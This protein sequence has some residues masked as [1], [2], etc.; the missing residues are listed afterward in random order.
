MNYANIINVDKIINQ[1]K[2]MI[3]M[4]ETWEEAI[5]RLVSYMAERTLTEDDYDEVE[6]KYGCTITIQKAYFV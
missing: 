1:R 6:I 2:D 3:I 5:D 4:G